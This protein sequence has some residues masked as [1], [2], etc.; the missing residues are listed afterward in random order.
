MT[1]IRHVAVI[2]I[3][4]TNAKLALVEM[5]SLSEIAVGKMANTVLQDGLYPHFDVEALWRFIVDGLAAHQRAHGVDAIS[6]TTHGACAA[7]MDAGDNLVLPVLDYEY[8]GYGEAADLYAAL[9]PSFAETG[10]PHLPLGLNLGAQIFWQQ[11]AFPE[12]FA[13]TSKILM[14]PQYWAYRL[15]GVAS[16]EVTSLGCHTDLWSPTAGDYSSLVDKMGWRKLM[17]PLW[18]ATKSLGLITPE[19]AQLTGLN[20]QTPVA[21][22]IHDSNASLVPHLLVHVKPFSVVSTGT[23]V[24]SMAIGGKPTSLDEHRDTLV[25]VNAFA[26]AVPSARFMGGREFQ[27]ILGDDH[28]TATVADVEAVLNKGIFLLPSIVQGSGPYADRAANWIGS[29]NPA[30]RQVAGSFYLGL[31]TA[32]CLDLIGAEGETIVE[33]PFASNANFLDMLEIATGRP[34]ATSQNATT[35]TTIGASLLLAPE[36]MVKAP[37][38][39]RTITNRVPLLAYAKQWREF[40]G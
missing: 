5:G 2:D 7:L 33:G 15:T 35:G 8:D 13:R 36:K 16:N 3:G 39:K 32:T 27:L 29:P 6:V 11:K 19:V 26:E 12:A 14:Y 22:G 34:T 10:S 25:N 1:K 9:R 18:P 20:P 30:E 28:S 31:M 37:G 17:A 21:C 24:I 4:K 23:W 40:L 38:T